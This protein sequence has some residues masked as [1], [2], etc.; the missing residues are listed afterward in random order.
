MNKQGI[1]DVVFG[2]QYGDEGKG[3]YLDMLAKEHDHEKKPK[4]AGIIRPQGGA[5]AGHTLYYKGRKFVG[6][7]LPSGMFEWYMQMLLGAHVIVDPVQ[8][9][10][11]RTAEP[12]AEKG[13]IVILQE[14]FNI[15]VTNRF[16]I[17][18]NAKLQ[19]PYDRI[20]DYAE[21]WIAK[22]AKRVKEPVGSTVRGIGPTYANDTAR[23]GLRVGDLLYS[24]FEAR[25]EALFNRQSVLLSTFYHHGLGVPVPAELLAQR[26]EDWWDYVYK[27]QPHI[28]AINEFVGSRLA[29]GQNFLSE[30]AQGARLD[31]TWANYPFVTSSNTLPSVIAQSIGVP[32]SYVKNVCAVLKFYESKVGGGFNPSRISNPRVEKLFQDA[33]NEKGATTG[34]LRDCGWLDMPLVRYYL[35]MSGANQVYIAKADICPV[36]KVQVVETYT[37]PSGQV[38]DGLGALPHRFSDLQN[39]QL[40]EFSG[41]EK[42]GKTLSTDFWTGLFNYFEND[43]LQSCGPHMKIVGV[44][45][46]PNPED[47]VV[48]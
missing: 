33:G 1:I 30:G 27:L 45:T 43:L 13:E 44:G 10:G 31:H 17:A 4:Y 47:H 23:H 18:Q 20:F 40:K 29:Q 34:R 9:F 14:D 3:K 48:C 38:I 6:H 32:Q 46:G 15:D 37:T 39:P 42:E 28:V 35:R 11:N 26:I 7:L 5:N 36:D 24:D 22:Q 21:E 19:S 41:W 25:A 16:F 8:L 2:L 12:R